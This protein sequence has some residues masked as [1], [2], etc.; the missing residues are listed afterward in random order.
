MVW[1]ELIETKG[2]NVDLV[3]D[4][5]LLTGG[6]VLFLVSCT[7][8]I[9]NEDRRKFNHV[10]VLHASDLPKGRGWSPHIW[11]ILNGEKKIVVTLLEAVDQ[12]DSGKVWLKASFELE[13][14][15]LA[16]EINTALFKVELELMTTAI[17]KATDIHPI[18]QTGPVGPYWPKRTPENSRIDPDKT[19]A[20]QFDLMR[21][22]DN[23]RYPCFFEYMGK[24]YIL[25]LEKVDKSE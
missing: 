10:L 25:K 23:Q 16:E 9:P 6:D 19:I 20:E 13:G 21:V 14:H 8:I 24:R 11:A 7:Q 2:H 4:K 5:S 12:V 3:N 17:V 22:A 15:E 18:D 1:K